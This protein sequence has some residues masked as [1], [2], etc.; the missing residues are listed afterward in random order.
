MSSEE[1]ENATEFQSS[2]DQI[3]WK[4][5]ENFSTEWE[6]VEVKF[7]GQ[8]DKDTSEQEK[9]LEGPLDYQFLEERGFVPY[10]IRG[11][12]QFLAFR[13]AQ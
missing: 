1:W 5:S 4:I 2:Q 3:S 7:G 8:V 6:A 13:S 12:G 10:N 9:R 11:L